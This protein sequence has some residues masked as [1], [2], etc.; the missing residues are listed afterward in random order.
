ML[1]ETANQRRYF[2]YRAKVRQYD[3][4]QFLRAARQSPFP[5]AVVF[6]VVPYQ[7]IRIQ[8]GRIRWEEEEAK[9]SFGRLNE[10]LYFPGSVGWV[11]I[12]DEENGVRSTVHQSFQ[13]LTEFAGIH[14]SL[15]NHETH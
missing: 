3:P 2:L 6:Q 13:E 4:F 12:D 5:C 1:K 10:L 8:F 15:E 7:F 14:P 11:S 9:H